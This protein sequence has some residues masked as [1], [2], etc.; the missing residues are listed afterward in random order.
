MQRADNRVSKLLRVAEGLGV[1]ALLPVPGLIEELSLR[2]LALRAVRHHDQDGA[3]LARLAILLVRGGEAGGLRSAVA[4]ADQQDDGIGLSHALEAGD[5]R[6]LRCRSE[7]LGTNELVAERSDCPRGRLPQFFH[8]RYRRTDEHLHLRIH[9][10]A[11]QAYATSS[12]AS[13]ISSQT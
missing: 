9:N 6:A 1:V 8:A 2:A 5:L 13:P 12:A 10:N 4:L 11:R 3:T 7:V